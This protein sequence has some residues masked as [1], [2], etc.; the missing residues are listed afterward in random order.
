MQVGGWVD[1]WVDEWVANSRFLVH[2]LCGSG[3]VAALLSWPYALFKYVQ[4]L[5]ISPV[6]L[7]KYSP[8]VLERTITI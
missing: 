4:L 8:L 1:R 7:I 6:P 5:A 3:I 2:S